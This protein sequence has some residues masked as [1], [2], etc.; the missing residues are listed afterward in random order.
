MLMP[1]MS[2]KVKLRRTIS[3]VI[4]SR[5]KKVEVTLVWL[6]RDLPKSPWRMPPAHLGVLLEP[7]AVE[8]MSLAE[9][10]QVLRT[11]FLAQ[12]VGRRVAGDEA[13]QGEHE[14]RD[15]EQVQREACQPPRE[16]RA[17]CPSFSVIAVASNP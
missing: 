8:T 5:S 12:D 1:K 16:I 13:E 15:E 10:L 6:H 11:C 3:S 2:V 4:G 17:H 7:G 14:D 9:L